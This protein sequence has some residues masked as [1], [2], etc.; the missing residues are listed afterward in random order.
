MKCRLC[1][2]SSNQKIRTDKIFGAKKPCKFWEC[3]NCHVFYQSPHLT[4]EEETYFYANE[5]EKFMHSRGGSESGWFNLKKHKKANT[6]NIHRRKEIL[7]KYFMRANTLLEIGCSSGFMFDTYREENIVYEGVEPSGVF[8]KALIENNEVIYNSL[9]QVPKHKMF[10]LILSYFVFEHIADP[11][12]FINLSLKHIN[13]GGFF[14]AEV[15]LANDVLVNQLNNVEFEEFYWSIAHHYYYTKDSLEYLLNDMR[16][17]FLL[18]PDQR[19]DLSNHLFWLKEGQPGGQGFFSNMIGP[20]VENLYKER[21]KMSW[22]CD[23]AFIV[24][25]N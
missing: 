14:I 16:L 19:Y 8:S 23:T 9:S 11:R 6:D 20:E 17:D 5:F 2:S 12:E 18:L 22:N 10:D 7:S 4:K 15:P 24:I 13:K 21:L 3:G 1:S 25:K